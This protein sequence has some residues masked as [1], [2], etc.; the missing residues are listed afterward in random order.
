MNTRTETPRDATYHVPD[1]CPELGP[2]RVVTGKHNNVRISQSHRNRLDKLREAKEYLLDEIKNDPMALYLME[3]E[4][5]VN[6]RVR[7]MIGQP[8]WR[9]FSYKEL[10]NMVNAD[11]H[12]HGEHVPIIVKGGSGGKLDSEGRPVTSKLTFRKHLRAQRQFQ[13]EHQA[14]TGNYH[15]KKFNSDFVEDVKKARQMFQWTQ[16]ELAEKINHP[17]KDIKEFEQGKAIYDPELKIALSKVF[18]FDSR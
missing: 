13:M 18:N 16:T 5:D 4:N 6:H 11:I 17:V 3:K 12:S 9:N 15:H 10:Y 7:S 14:D 8:Q 2:F 1:T